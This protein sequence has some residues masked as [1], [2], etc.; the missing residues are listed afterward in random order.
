MSSEKDGEASERTAR[1]ELQTRPVARARRSVSPDKQRQ[2]V[3]KSNYWDFFTRS[4]VNGVVKSKCKHCDVEYKIIQGSTTNMK[5][6]LAARHPEFL[7]LVNV[8]EL[9]LSPN[10][11]PLTPQN[12]ERSLV[13]WVIETDQ[14]FSSVEHPF[15]K[16]LSKNVLGTGTVNVERLMAGID[17]LYEEKK[18]KLQNVLKSIPGKISISLDLWSSRNSHSFLGVKAHYVDSNWEIKEVLIDFSKV[19]SHK[20]EDIYRRIDAVLGTYD[21]H[22]RVI[23]VATDNASNNDTFINDLR[24]DMNDIPLI[25]CMAHIINL[26]VQDFLAEFDTSDKIEDKQQQAAWKN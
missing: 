7:N 12:Y 4:E 24:V 3:R 22:D 16:R 13:E 20:G 8:E 1:P 15:I 23:A 17:L 6:H 5:N 18:R 2:L 10:E 21:L 14:A 26:S 25:R 19:V 11:I 9:V